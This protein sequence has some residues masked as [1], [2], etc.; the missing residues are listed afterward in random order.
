MHFL[1]KSVLLTSRHEINLAVLFFLVKPVFWAFRHELFTSLDVGV[2][3]V[4]CGAGVLG[5]WTNLLLLTVHSL[6]RVVV[7]NP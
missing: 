6:G 2:L 7:F 3:I 5:L 1:V 4:W